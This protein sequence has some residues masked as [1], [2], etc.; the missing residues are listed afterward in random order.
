VEPGSSP[1]ADKGKGKN[2]ASP[3]DV[4]DND[5]DNDNDNDADVVKDPELGEE[6]EGNAM[7][8]SDDDS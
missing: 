2:S 7:Q 8:L 1:P 4:D 3:I 6:D 5:N